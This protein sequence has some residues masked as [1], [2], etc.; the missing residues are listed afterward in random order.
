[1]NVCVCVCKLWSTFLLELFVSGCVLI[2]LSCQ[3]KKQKI[4]QKQKCQLVLR[5][6]VNH[7][8]S[9]AASLLLLLL[10]GTQKCQWLGGLLSCSP[11][12]IYFA[13]FYC[14]ARSSS[15]PASLCD[16]AVHWHRFPKAVADVFFWGCVLPSLKGTKW[17]F[18]SLSVCVFLFWFCCFFY[19]EI[20]FNMA[21]VVEVHFS[22]LAHLKKFQHEHWEYI[23]LCRARLYIYESRC[24]KINI[25]MYVLRMQMLIVITILSA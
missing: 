13:H 7:N 11:P 14:V 22:T 10:Y 17:F 12:P 15:F 21:H 23:F 8:K 4:K 2:S 1:M 25:R 16:A 3:N 6:T 19:I 9:T 24:R 5:I 20:H 18:V